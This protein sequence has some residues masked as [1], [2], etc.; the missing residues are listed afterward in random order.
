MPYYREYDSD[1]EY[2]ERWEDYRHTV[3][4]FRELKA[5]DDKVAALRLVYN[6]PETFEHCPVQLMTQEMCDLAVKKDPWNFQYVPEQFK[7]QEMCDFAIKENSWLLEYVPDHFKTQE[8]CDFAVDDCPWNF[9]YVPDQFKSVEMSYWVGFHDAISDKETQEIIDTLRDPTWCE[10]T[11]YLVVDQHLA[12]LRSLRMHFLKEGFAIAA[13]RP[14]R[15]FSEL[16]GT[17]TSDML[18]GL[19]EDERS[20]YTE[21]S[22]L[23]SAGEA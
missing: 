12:V 15:I 17:Y 23:V 6:E 7:T 19:E 4:A 20:W 13:G 8:M 10:G 3:A 2:D 1:D 16:S 11:G 21:L 9:K 14:E 18:Q 5:R 22:G